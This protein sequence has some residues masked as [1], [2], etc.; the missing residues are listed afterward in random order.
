M[1]APQT[2]RLKPFALRRLSCR[3]YPSL[4]LSEVG[5][6]IHFTELPKTTFVGPRGPFPCVRGHRSRTEWSLARRGLVPA[7]LEVVDDLTARNASVALTS[8]SLLAWV[9]TR[10][11]ENRLRS[12]GWPAFRP[13]YIAER[14]LRVETFNGR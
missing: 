2:D 9:P 8:A 3:D 5:S 4:V 6:N 12:G 10:G 7:L 13:I 1:T 14:S 11:R